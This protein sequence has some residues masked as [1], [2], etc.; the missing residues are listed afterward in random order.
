MDLKKRV[1]INIQRNR[2]AQKLT[3]EEFAERLGVTREYIS[4]VE[5]GKSGLGSLDLIS[6]IAQKLNVDIDLLLGGEKRKSPPQIE[7]AT[8][9]W[10]DE[11]VAAAQYLMD[12]PKLLSNA[13]KLAEVMYQLPDDTLDLLV[14][15]FS[16][17]QRISPES[18]PDDVEPKP[19]EPK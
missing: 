11:E 10:T 14:D 12:H 16:E 8:D 15:F 17:M 9:E 5:N 13:A 1:G 7:A 18:I 4:N 3:Q 2:K 6:D 19:W